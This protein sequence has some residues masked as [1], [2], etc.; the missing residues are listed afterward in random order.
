MET[1]TEQMDLETGQAPAMVMVVV[2]ATLLVMETLLAM[3][4]VFPFLYGKKITR[5]FRK[6]GHI[7]VIGSDLDSLRTKAEAV[8]KAI[9][10]KS[11]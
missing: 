4:G 9:K 2:L 5:P 8:K 6:M 1:A 7:T 10:V 3:P 11:L